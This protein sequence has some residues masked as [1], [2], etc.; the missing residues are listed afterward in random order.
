MYVHTSTYVVNLH[1]AM[2]RDTVRDPISL[3]E[4]S[5]MTGVTLT[6]VSTSD[7]R[8]IIS[9]LVGALRPSWRAH[10]KA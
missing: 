8:R 2:A 9:S 3:L 7:K 5:G 6:Q 1:S 4:W 10:I